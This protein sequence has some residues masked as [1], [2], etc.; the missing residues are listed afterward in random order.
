MKTHL[1]TKKRAL[2][3]SVAMLLVAIIALGTATFAWFTQDTEAYADN[4]YVRTTKVSNLLLNSKK[5]PTWRTHVDYGVGSPDAKKKLMPV[6]TADGTN[7]Y[8]ASAEKGDS[9]IA[10]KAELLTKA[11]GEN[12]NYNDYY[13][14]DQL[15]IRNDGQADCDQVKIEVTGLEGDYSRIAI[16]PVTKA[17]GTTIDPI[18]NKKLWSDYIIDND[19]KAYNAAAG[20]ELM[21]KV[22]EGKY[23]VN[24]DSVVS[25][26]PSVDKI[27]NVG[28]IGAGKEKYFNVFVWFEGQDEDC[29]N[30][31]SGQFIPQLKF[32]VSGVAAGDTQAAEGGK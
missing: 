24:T 6:S 15:N 10:N 2:I 9:F 11:I 16:V 5:D 20:T 23:E 12:A 13:F 19:G 30:K 25:V 4:M 26:T 14:A 8:S 21:T 22:A 31:N 1:L 32:T 18:G 17:G 3:S 28:S 7:W 29:Q 27:I